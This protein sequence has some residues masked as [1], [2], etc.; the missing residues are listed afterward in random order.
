MSSQ[1]QI[2]E[3]QQVRIER[4]LSIG[5]LVALENGRRGLIRA[6]ELRWEDIGKADWRR[7][8]AV[9]GWYRAKMI[10][11][12]GEQILFS[13]RFAQ[14]DPWD[15]AAV[16]YRL[17]TIHVGVVSGFDGPLAYIDLEPGIVGRLHRSELPVWNSAQIEEFLWLGDSIRVLVENV[18]LVRREVILTMRGMERLRWPGT[19]EAKDGQSIRREFAPQAATP[20]LTIFTS[21][22]P[23]SILVIED[24]PEQS[25]ALCGWLRSAGHSVESALGETEAKAA[26]ARRTFEAILSDVG[27]DD[28]DGIGFVREMIDQSPDSRWMLM[29]D[30]ASAEDRDTEIRSLEEKGVVLLLK[31]LSPEDM[32]RVL[33]EANESE[34]ADEDDEPAETQI[35]SIRQV[36]AQRRTHRHAINSTGQ[37]RQLLEQLR[38]TSRASRVILFRL[39]AHQRQIDIA[40]DT[41]EGGLDLNA[42]GSLI[43]SPV[44]EVLDDQATV[45][46]PDVGEA[47]GY[48]RNL[49]PL[50]RFRSCI[51]VPVPTNIEEEY[52]L[53]LFHSATGFASSVVVQDADNTALALAARLE[54]QTALHQMIEV[55]RSSLIG[56]LARGMVHEVNHHLGPMVWV[57]P[58]VQAT[59]VRFGQTVDVLLEQPPAIPNGSINPLTDMRWELQK[60]RDDIRVLG[61]GINNLVQTTRL[62]GRIT[63]QDSEQILRMERVVELCFDMVRDMADRAKIQLHFEPPEN[64]HL[65]RARESQIQQILLNL[66]V[67]AIQQVALIRPKEGGRIQVEV[68][69]SEI[70][71]ERAIT[72]SVEDDGPGIHRRL[73]EPI[74]RLGMTTRQGEGSGMGLYIAEWLAG[75]LGGIVQVQ[76]GY[77]GWGS[78]FVIELPV[79]S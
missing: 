70:D 51:G 14:H 19:P 42:L 62:F 46:V 1:L 22:T 15:T 27:L 49:T 71:G 64:I 36:T 30:W 73:W 39:H 60:L 56:H 9:N 68:G 37:I 25:R 31:P 75:D 28:G 4:I 33:A 44:R 12:E 74:F 3:I 26:L 67:N 16:R 2:G 35:T 78:R 61:D 45:Q 58:R 41:S 65:T 5:L 54:Q 8:Y 11:W 32:Q 20:A 48:T 21:A 6:R 43:H 40:G 77:V 63:V 72:I 59:S 17:G 76:E 23:R 10:G 66:L 55:Q 7:R 57:I 47:E 24:D 69:S 38:K 52:A 13:L 50:L 79:R 18:N 53:F 34:Q 29:T